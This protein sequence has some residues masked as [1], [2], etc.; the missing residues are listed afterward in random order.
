MT[1]LPIGLTEQYKEKVKG[2]S[3]LFYEVFHVYFY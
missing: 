3:Y 2:V 1:Y